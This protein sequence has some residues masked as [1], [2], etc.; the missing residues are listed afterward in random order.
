[1]EG[2]KMKK[3]VFIIITLTI[4]LMSYCTFCSETIYLDIKKHI[5]NYK[6]LEISEYQYKVL[7]SLQLAESNGDYA[8][9]QDFRIHL[10]VDSLGEVKYLKIVPLYTVEN[11]TIQ[12]QHEFANIVEDIIKKS[13]LQWQ[14]N[15]PTL[16][17]KGLSE[18][19]K[20]TKFDISLYYRF[21]YNKAGTGQNST[22]ISTTI[23]S[24]I[25]ESCP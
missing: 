15:I 13:I 9:A 2:N 3:N 24:F 8:M 11:G 10:K 19:D 16:F 1:M 21:Y 6:P 14:I 17:P 5:N 7:D 23:N 25:Y 4:T 12:L 18:I 22:K 20:I